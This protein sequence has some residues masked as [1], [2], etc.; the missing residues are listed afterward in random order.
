MDDGEITNIGNATRPYTEADRLA[1][2]RICVSS[3][4]PAPPTVAY[5]ADSDNTLRDGDAARRQTMRPFAL[6]IYAANRTD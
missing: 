6:R 5:A 2:L 4:R 1:P 3:T